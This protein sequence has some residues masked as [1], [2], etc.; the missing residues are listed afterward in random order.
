MPSDLFDDDL[1][2]D[3]LEGRE[4]ASSLFV[5]VAEDLDD[6]ASLVFCRDYDL[7]RLS[8]WKR[9]WMFFGKRRGLGNAE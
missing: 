4:A 5:R 3:L 9:L 7:N 1:I 2:D 6:R 8:I